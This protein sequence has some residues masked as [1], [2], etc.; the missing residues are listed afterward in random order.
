MQIKS[1]LVIYNFW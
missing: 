1:D